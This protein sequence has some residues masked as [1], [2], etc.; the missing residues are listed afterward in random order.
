MGRSPV[1]CHRIRNYGYVFRLMSF[2][3]RWGT[4]DG[5]NYSEQL[6]TSRA[7]TGADESSWN[8]SDQSCSS[9]VNLRSDFHLCLHLCKPGRAFI[10]SQGSRYQS[11]CNCCVIYMLHWY[12]VLGFSNLHWKISAYFNWRIRKTTDE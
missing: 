4:A 8:K 9:T 10:F 3:L 12:Y 1:R 7:W 11:Y 5:G 2:P 6:C